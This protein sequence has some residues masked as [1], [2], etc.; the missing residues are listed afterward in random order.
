MR[1]WSIS[2]REQ[3]TLQSIDAMP[4]AT[5]LRVKT[6]AALKGCSIATVWRHAKQGL[7][8]SPR[9]SGGI[10]TWNLGELRRSRK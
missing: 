4:D 9:K 3:H 10:T 5:E 7:L 1:P 8:P 6:V 2:Q